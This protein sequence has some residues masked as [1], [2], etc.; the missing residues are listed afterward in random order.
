LIGAALSGPIPFII[1]YSI[2]T[3]AINWAKGD[4]S[5]VGYYP[6]SISLSPNGN[7]AIILIPAQG[8]SN[9]G[10]VQVYDSNHFGAL[11][12]SSSYTSIT[13]NT[14]PYSPNSK[15]VLINSVG[16]GA[17]FIDRYIKSSS[18]YSDKY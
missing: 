3:A 14:E 16:N 6:I 9:L 11:I 13:P 10:Y 5:K 15:A 17:Y 1:S 18:C 4:L 12:S 7:Y 8:S 2:S